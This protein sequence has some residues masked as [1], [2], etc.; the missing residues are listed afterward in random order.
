MENQQENERYSEYGE[1]S[2]PFCCLQ[3]LNIFA[4]NEFAVAVPDAFPISP[5]HTLIIPRR[6][7]SSLFD[8][9][10]DEKA[11]LM[12]LLAEARE[13]IRQERNAEGFNIAINEGSVAG[14]TI[15]HLHIHLIPRY[16]GDCCD[17][18]GGVRKLFPD[19]TPNRQRR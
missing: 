6:H 12:E 4:A 16:Q 18:R 19:K 2:C 15:F 3:L 17:P 7:F 8:A 1:S 13:R 14:Q 11:A 10:D 5:G 9:S